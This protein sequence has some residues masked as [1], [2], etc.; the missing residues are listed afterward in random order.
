MTDK[1]NAQ[2]DVES[3]L[4]ISL[5]SSAQS[6]SSAE[7]LDTLLVITYWFHLS[8]AI[9]PRVFSHEMTNVSGQNSSRSQI[10]RKTTY[11][12]NVCG[13]GKLIQLEI[14]RWR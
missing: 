4:G 10:Q 7:S 11:L 5:E 1:I 9:L 12:Y 8:M 6:F 13:E 14:K 2:D 3:K